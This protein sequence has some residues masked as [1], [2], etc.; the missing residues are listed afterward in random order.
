MD[1][2]STLQSKLVQFVRSELSDN[3]ILELVSNSMGGAVGESIAAQKK[4]AK[5]KPSP[6]VKNVVDLGG[7]AQPERRGAKATVVTEEVLAKAERYIHSSNGVALADVAQ[8]LGLEKSSTQRVVDKLK[9]QGRVMMA[10]ERSKS[11]Y[12]KDA[13]TALAASTRG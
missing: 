2:Q 7:A 12:A 11:R 5:A 10:G 8:F 6:K 9:K 3:E 1:M 4:P 13:K